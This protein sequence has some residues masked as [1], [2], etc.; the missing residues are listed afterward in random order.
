MRLVWILMLSAAAMAQ[1]ARTVDDLV[2]FIKTAIAQKNA[3]KDIAAAVAG[4]RLANRLDEKTVVELQRLGAGQKTV[5]AL[6]H[7]SETSASLPP[8][9]AVVVKPA[10]E[11]PP[12]PTPA[13]FQAIMT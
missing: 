12:P 3:D 5:A 8:A 1:P 10:A 9:G 4:I 6:K 7:L 2:S 11:G 13:E